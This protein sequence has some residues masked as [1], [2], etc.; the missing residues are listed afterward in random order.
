MGRNRRDF[1]KATA[2]ISVLGVS[3]AVGE[4]AQQRRTGRPRTNPKIGIV[5]STVHHPN[6]HN[7]FMQALVDKGWGSKVT[8]QPFHQLGDPDSNPYGD[9]RP[10]LKNLAKAFISNGV[11]V[12]LVV[13]AGGLICGKAAKEAFAEIGQSAKDV[14]FIFI[15]GTQST[16][17]DSPNKSGGVDLNTPAQND[18]RVTLLHGK[19]G[20]VTPQNVSLIVNANAAMADAE[21]QT[22]VT[23]GHSANL[24]VRVFPNQ[25]PNRWDQ[26][27]TELRQVATLNPQPQAIV[28]SSDPFFR[29][30]RTN[31]DTALR[32]TNGGN[33]SGWVCYPFDELPKGGNKN[34]PT[35]T[36]PRLATS[37]RTNKEAA[38]YK[39]GLKA[40]QVLVGR[41]N[42]IKVPPIGVTQWNG[43][44]WIEL[45]S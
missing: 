35:D 38:Y 23:G 32:N 15:V 10:D 20:Q 44:T 40:V 41:A 37:D 17:L 4:P 45:S 36:S 12:D 29:L 7:A 2:A 8:V 16:D 5:H 30:H 1:I 42:N 19:D 33:F 14:P 27:Q 3:E 21:V 39:L 43:S 26:L 18:Y 11:M 24:V 31:F 25:G 34:I 9:N 6:M 13:A 22:W 28:V